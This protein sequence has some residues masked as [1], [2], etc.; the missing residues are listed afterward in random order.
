M[1]K[2]KRIV[3]DIETK[4]FTE[5]FNKEKDLAI[6]TKLSPK[7]R[8]ACVYEEHTNKYFFYLPE[9]S[10]KLVEK[11]KKAD[12]V[13]SYNGNSFDYLVLRKHCGLPKDYPKNK[14]H[15]DLLELIEKQF[16]YKVSLDKMAFVNLGEG[17]HTSG[18]SILHLNYDK[19]K[20]ACKSDV[21]QTYELWKLYS[22]KMLKYPQKNVSKYNLSED[23]P[24][25]AH[26]ILDIPE[27]EG[28][29]GLE[30][31]APMSDANESEFLALQEGGGDPAWAM[32]YFGVTGSRNVEF[33]TET[34][35]SKKKKSKR[36]K[37]T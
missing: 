15:V 7:M 31:L 33:T 14:Q 17:K 5:E 32:D 1:A 27:L 35:K 24:G 6:K 22:K 23:E 20:I 13:I 11:I 18:R 3:F 4:Q 16:G 29:Y 25:P 28:E 34:E 30:N 10:K 19:L 12:Q 26:P 2:I 21:V 36:K 9:D 8:L 37:R